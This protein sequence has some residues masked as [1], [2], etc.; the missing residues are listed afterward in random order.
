MLLEF[1][2]P[3][4]FTCPWADGAHYTVCLFAPVS[5]IMSVQEENKTRDERSLQPI[6]TVYIVS[7]SKDSW[8]NYL[9]GEAG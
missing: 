2:T 4:V 5:C 3:A 8:E 7:D 1:G 9:A 6:L